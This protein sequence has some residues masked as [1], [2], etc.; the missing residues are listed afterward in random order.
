MLAGWLQRQWFEQRRLSPALWL[1]LPLLLPLAGL[2][3]F[4][5]WVN[6][7]Q[8]RPVRLPV[9]VVVVGNI[10]VGGA[11]KTPLTIWLAGQLSARGWRP[12]IVSRGYGASNAQARPVLSTSSPAEVGDEPILLA[13]R[14][15]RPVWVGRDR[16]AAGQA[17]L[18]A[19]P[20]VNIVLCDDGLQHYRLARDVELAVFDGRGAGNGWRLP[21]GPL[22]ES[23]SR[24]ATVDAVVCNGLPDSR[25]G[26]AVAQFAM[27]LRAENFYRLGDSRQTCG[28]ESLAGRKL[29]ALAGIGDPGRFFRTLAGLGLVCAEHPFPDHHAYSAA[30]LA[31]AGDGILLMTEKDAVKCAGLTAGETWVLP[32]EAELSPALI[33][34]ILEKLHGRQAA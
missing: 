22:R 29:Y 9:P 33:E 11:G 19:H 18:A 17:L 31:F 23:L 2:F 10:T 16:V 21:L 26:E 3:V 30:D 28:A 14:S 34:L 15:G 12:G 24:L 13:R 7:R 25:I 1:L 5:A 8:A 20:E 27:R 6:R 32:V 4:L